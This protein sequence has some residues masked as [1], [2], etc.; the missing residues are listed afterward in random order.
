MLLICGLGNKGASYRYTRHNVG[1]LVLDR[2][3]DRFGIPFAKKIDG[4]VTGSSEGLLLAKPDTYMNLSGMPLAA[5]MRK[6][7]I[8][9]ENLIVV[10]DDLDMDYGRIRF[11]RDGGDGGHK[12]IRSIAQNLQSRSFYRLKIGIGR[13]PAVVP[14]EYVLSRFTMEEAASLGDILDKAVDSLD[15]FLTEGS[16]KAMNQFNR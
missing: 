13:D 5:L 15:V 6:K 9:P 3:S 12:G 1:Y 8:A 16:Q 4:C 11:K 2:V 10:H 7:G 14:E